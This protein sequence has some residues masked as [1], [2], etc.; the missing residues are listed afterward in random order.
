[1]SKYKFTTYKVDCAKTRLKA[2]TGNMKSACLQVG[3]LIG[4]EWYN[5]LTPFGSA[6]SKMWGGNEYKLHLFKNKA[7][8]NSFFLDTKGTTLIPFVKES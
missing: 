5:K 8:Y 1:M 2:K 4:S 7:G 3:I 6:E